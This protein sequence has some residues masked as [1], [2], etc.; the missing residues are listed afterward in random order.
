VIQKK[1][2]FFQNTPFF[3]NNSKDNV[4]FDT[5]I[6]LP[7]SSTVGLAIKEVIPIFN[8]IFV[9]QKCS[10]SLAEDTN[11][12]ELFVAKKNGQPNPDFPALDPSQVLTQIGVQRF[13]LVEKDASDII[14]TRSMK[15]SK[16]THKA[17]SRVVE[18]ELGG[19][20]G[21]SSLNEGPGNM[22]DPDVFG[23]RDK[24]K[25]SKSTRS[26]EDEMMKETY[27]SDTRCCCIKVKSK[28]TEKIVSNISLQQEYNKNNLNEKLL[29]NQ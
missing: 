17:D 7:Q 20:S 3:W 8:S 27:E 24:N 4:K 19:K 11:S 2:R 15:S 21:K 18:P 25:K 26:N 14:T 13:T 1:I 23:D 22:L 9:N 10:F 5:I 28:R 29:A 12:Y 6:E 16:I